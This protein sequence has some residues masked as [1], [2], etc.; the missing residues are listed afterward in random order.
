MKRIDNY[1]RLFFFLFDALSSEISS[2]NEVYIDSFEILKFL[3]R[4]FATLS[5]PPILSKRRGKGIMKRIDDYTRLLLFL[6]DA[7]RR[8]HL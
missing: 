4:Y 1:T 8:Y 3:L 6:F 5:F 7:L 2:V